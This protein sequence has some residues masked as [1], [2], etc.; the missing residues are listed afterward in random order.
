[1]SS[2]VRH[3]C[4]VFLN[5]EKAVITKY[6]V[7]ECLEVTSTCTCQEADQVVQN[8][9]SSVQAELTVF[10]WNFTTVCNSLQLEIASG[11]RNY[12]PPRQG[13]KLA[14]KDEG[15]HQEVKSIS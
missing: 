10:G 6:D 14:T 12:E 7:E 11:G 9:G 3:A 5:M 1:M 13:Q 2:Q 4:A 15:S 8:A